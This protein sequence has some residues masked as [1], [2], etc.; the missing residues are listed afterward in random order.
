[1]YNNK[2]SHN[3]FERKKTMDNVRRRQILPGI[4]LTAVNTDKF[5]TSCLSI[6]LLRPLLSE[7]ASKNALIPRLLRRGTEQYPD[8]T[9]LSAALDSLYGA[10]IEP[11]VRK[12]G[13]I[14]TIGFYADFIDQAYV[15]GKEDMLG[16]IGNLICQILFH[17][18]IKDG[19]FVPEYLKS[20]RENLINAIG[21]QMN[22]KRLYAQTRMLEHMCA[23]EAYGTDRY[24]SVSQVRVIENSD[25]TAHYQKVLRHS[26]M[27]IFYCGS[28]LF[29]QVE[30]TVRNIFSDLDRSDPDPIGTV[31][32]AGVGDVRAVTE[33]MDVTQGKLVLGMRTGCIA[34]DEAFPALMLF[35]ALY[36]GTV[37]SKLFMNVRERLS[38]CYYASS[39]LEKLKGLLIV[40]SG[41][42][43]GNYEVAKDEI[44]TQLKACKNGDFEG[45]ELEAARQSIVSSLKTSLDSQFALEDFYLS[46]A[47]ADLSYGPLELAAEIEDV[48]KEQ[49]VEAAKRVQLD[50][51]YFLKGVEV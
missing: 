42:E 8:Q 34:E 39:S 49:V 2:D 50:T 31:V 22:D 24:G 9:A 47:V 51:I 20:E 44:L 14:Q 38:L 16:E 3:P 5:K 41:I 7:E 30:Q 35:N 40:S 23:G 4:Y 6:N 36:G 46:Q 17:P 13:E 18:A 25:L 11:I 43:F 48:T 1:M 26:Q 37:T 45:P 10:S 27:E 32:V 28:I 15:P 21:T 29:E 33:S 19:M 12:K